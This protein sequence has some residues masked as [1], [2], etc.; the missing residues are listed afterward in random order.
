MFQFVAQIDATTAAGIGVLLT[1]LLLGIR[2]GIDWDH[3]AAITDITSTTA[4][5]TAAEAAH[6]QDHRTDEA[7]QHGHGGTTELQAHGDTP[8][9]RTRPI[10]AGTA[11]AGGGV[12]SA[13]VARAGVASA[14]VASASFS[15]PGATVL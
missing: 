5:A 3:I 4:A 7:H 13:G 1:G 10:P 14:G 15:V 6:A 9:T 2:H 11:V 8:G 12:A